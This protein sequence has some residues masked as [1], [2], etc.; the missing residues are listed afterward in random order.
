MDVWFLIFF[1]S[2][3]FN[4]RVMHLMRQMRSN[5]IGVPIN[6]TFRKKSAL[7]DHH[8]PKHQ[9]WEKHFYWKIHFEFEFLFLPRGTKLIN[10]E[11]VKESIKMQIFPNRSFQKSSSEM[12][13]VFGCSFCQG[14]IKE[15]LQTLDWVSKRKAAKPIMIS[16]KIRARDLISQIKPNIVLFIIL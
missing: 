5:C 15:L 14:K 13:S 10:G 1:A 6:C 8:N 4:S 12:N 9:W 2:F 3:T 11:R 7:R 16:I